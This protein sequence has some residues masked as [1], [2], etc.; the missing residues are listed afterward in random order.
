MIGDPST[1]RG[2]PLNVFN[3][4]VAFT[5]ESFAGGGGGT[6]LPLVEGA[7]AEVSGLEATMEA[8]T[9]REGGL[10]HLS[11]QRV[12]TVS[13]ATVVLRRGM[14][15]ARDLWRWF[16]LLAGGQYAGRLTVAI[17]LRD[18]QGERLMSFRLLRALPVKFK[19]ADLN[20]RASEVGIEEVHLVHEGL[21]H[22]A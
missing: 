1:A 14:T 6:A 9:I 12:G 19:A 16:D 10:N 5:D 15:R 17:E 8:K 4:H 20:A 13:H 18:G 7:F 3:F 2:A 11:H 22:D 21:E